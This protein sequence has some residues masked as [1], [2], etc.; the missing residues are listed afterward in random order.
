M[1]ARA[2]STLPCALGFVKCVYAGWEEWEGR[3]LRVRS[4][5]EF[6]TTMKEILLAAAW[7]LLPLYSS[8]STVTLGKEQD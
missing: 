7:V 3:G 1:L 2:G 5:V 8:T 4:A 6:S